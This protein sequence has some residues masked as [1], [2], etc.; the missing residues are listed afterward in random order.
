MVW[1]CCPLDHAIGATGLYIRVEDMIKLGAFYLGRGEYRGIRIVSSERVAKVPEREYEFKPN[2]IKDSYNKGV[3]NG[4]E[5]LV[6][7]CENRVIGWMGYDTRADR[8]DITR[9]AAE[10]DFGD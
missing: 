8:P 5:L 6:V 10:Y 7:P 9:Y 4:Q 2:G 3:L 1:S